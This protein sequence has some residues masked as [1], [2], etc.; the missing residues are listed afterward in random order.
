MR[1]AA[2]LGHATA[3]LTS[4]WP[5]MGTALFHWERG[6]AGEFRDFRALIAHFTRA[7]REWQDFVRM[8][9]VSGELTALMNAVARGDR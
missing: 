2:R 8:H 5:S 6:C 3:L 9:L 1:H 7:E 4:N